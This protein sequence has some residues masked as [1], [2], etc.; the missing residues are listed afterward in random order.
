MQRLDAISAER[1]VA[2]E[3]VQRLA[4]GRAAAGRRAHAPHVEAP[5]VDARGRALD[6]AI[7]GEVALLHQAGPPDVVGGR[8]DRRVLRGVRDRT[9]QRAAVE[10]VRPEAGEVLVRP[11]QVGVAQGRA[12]VARRAVGVEV[13]RGRRRDVVE[14]VHVALGLVEE[15]LVD[16]EALAGDPGPGL[17]RLAQRLV[18]VAVE[19]ELPASHGAGD[20]GGKAAEARVVERQRHAVDHERVGP[21]RRGRGLAAVDRRDLPVLGAD[22]HEPAAAD[23]RRERL[24]HAQHAGRRDRRIDRVAAL[25]QHVDRGLRGQQVDRRR[26]P[27]AADRGRDLLRRRRG[28]M[29]L[30]VPLPVLVALRL[31]RARRRGR[32]GGQ[33]QRGGK[34]G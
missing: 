4:D 11:R 7:G 31:V 26:G 13:D 29:A 16:D 21:H 1:L 23:A 25:A 28:R 24:G 9:R 15:R 20:A 19:R 33:R 8:R 12:D 27:T 2:L 34:D 10:R 3:D 6:R 14:V 5:V 22:D 30:P 32:H 18:A 17:E